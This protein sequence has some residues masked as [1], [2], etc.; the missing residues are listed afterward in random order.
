M[1]NFPI[2]KMKSLYA[3]NS[4]FEIAFALRS[5]MMHTVVVSLNAILS[6]HLGTSLAL[7]FFVCEMFYI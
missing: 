7:L 6:L 2:L 3:L 5:T 4:T 1:G